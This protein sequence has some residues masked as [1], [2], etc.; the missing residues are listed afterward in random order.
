MPPFQHG[1]WLVSEN[2]ALYFFPTVPDS[3]PELNTGG[4]GKI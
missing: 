3:L 4:E 2:S 1:V